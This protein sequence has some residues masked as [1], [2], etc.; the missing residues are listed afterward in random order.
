MYWLIPKLWHLVQWLWKFIDPKI[1]DFPFLWKK[2]HS[3][4]GCP[5]TPSVNSAFCLTFL[6]EFSLV[7][8]IMWCENEWPVMW[9]LNFLWGS[10]FTM[11]PTSKKLT[12][13]IGFTSVSLSKTLHARV[14][15]LPIW[16]P[17]GK[18]SSTL[19]FLSEL[20]PFLELCPFEKIRIK[21][22]VCHILWT[23]H[24]RVLKFDYRFLMEK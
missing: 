7:N 21:F 22:Y 15:K 2:I 9:Y 19:F 3:V 16:I 23:M 14:L 10:L 1:T 4:F 17:H 24:A 20:S 8:V 12:G 5:M 18:N 11:P 13:H 6:T